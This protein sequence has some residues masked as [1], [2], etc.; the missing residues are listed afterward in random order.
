LEEELGEEVAERGMGR[1]WLEVRRERRWLEGEG[2]K[3][4]LEAERERRVGMGVGRRG[5]LSGVG[6]EVVGK[7]GLGRGCYGGGRGGREC[8]EMNERG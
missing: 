4:W 1:R 8:K 2:E 5:G 7:W 6:D 3:R